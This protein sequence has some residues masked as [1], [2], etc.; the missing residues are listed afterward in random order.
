M[1]TGDGDLL[2]QQKFSEL[3]RRPWYRSA[4][5]LL[6]C[7]ALVYFAYQRE[8]LGAFTGP[9]VAFLVVW[10][11][12]WWWA[13][14]WAKK[15]VMRRFAAA[16]GFS[17]AEDFD[18][19]PYTPLLRAGDKRDMGCTLQRDG[20]L[21]GHY[22]YTEVHHNGKGGTTETDYDW[23]IATTPV[24]AAMLA[25]PSLYLQPGG[26]GGWV[27]HGNLREMQ[28]REHRLQ[29]QVRG[30]LPRGPGRPRPAALPGPLEP[31]VA[32][33]PPAGVRRRD[34][35]RAAARLHRGPR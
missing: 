6:P 31:A 22:T 29:R 27:K 11:A 28:D 19:P 13:D 8:T 14:N 20:V 10:G 5:V 4:L 3:K 23:T 26:N 35:R 17:F 25:L 16:H 7:A 34:Q 2:R 33:R 24:E 15:E 21:L 18:P 32:A 12:G 30:L 1:R 9:L